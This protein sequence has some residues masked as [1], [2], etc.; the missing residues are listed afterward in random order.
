ML[1]FLANKALKHGIDEAAPGVM[2]RLEHSQ[3]EIVS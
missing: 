1:F 3:K 2:H